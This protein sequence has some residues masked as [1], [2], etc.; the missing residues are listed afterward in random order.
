MVEPVNLLVELSTSE[1]TIIHLG[2]TLAILL[3]G[4]FAVKGLRNLTERWLIT[5]QD[6]NKKSETIRSDRLDLASNILKAG[7]VSLA[8]FYLN[9]NFTSQALQQAQAQLPKLMTFVLGGLLGII[10]IKIATQVAK[11]FLKK[12]EVKDFIRDAGFSISSIRLLLGAFKGFLYILLFQ[13]LV[14]WMNI[15]ETFI[16]EIINASSWAITFLIAGLLFYGFKDL[17]R[18]LAAGVYLKN[19]RMVRPGEEV[20]M[21][22]EQGEIEEVSLFSTTVNTDSGY[23]VLTPNSKISE[24]NLKFRRTKSDLETLEEISEYFNIENSDYSA[25]VNLEIALEILGYRKS[26]DKVQKKIESKEGQDYERMEQTVAELTNH[27]LNT[28][29]IS[30][31]RISKIGDELKAWFN[32]EA[33]A[34]IKMR[35]EIED[36]PSYALAIAVENNDIL[37][38]DPSTKGIR[39]MSEEKLE[40]SVQ[41]EE[42][43]YLVIAPEN[44][45]SSWRIR[46]DLIYSEPGEYDELSK[47]LESRLRKIIRQG[48]IIEDI[49]PEPLKNYLEEWR[50]EEVSADLWKTEREEENDRTSEDN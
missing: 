5:N 22:D 45:I 2:F 36:E 14:S 46:N 23:T 29:W 11:K 42:G 10:G 19:S 1:S 50:T 28:A 4:Y 33:I 8:L 18:N 27:E 13:L 16:S 17:F 37:L 31:E 32:D 20:K 40:D 49:A 48:R 25:P 38:L 34:I 21:D 47:T 39:Y 12:K 24:N 41:T 6:I 3:A 44:T 7:V 30:H 9:A 43:G 15:G 35:N 26:Q